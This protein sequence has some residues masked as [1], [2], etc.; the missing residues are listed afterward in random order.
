MIDHRGIAHQRIEIV[1][2]HQGD[3]PLDQRE[4]GIC[5]ERC[6]VAPLE[7]GLVVGIEIIHSDYALTSRHQRIAEM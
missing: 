6:D 4:H 3:V 7:R 1:S 5:D 2:T